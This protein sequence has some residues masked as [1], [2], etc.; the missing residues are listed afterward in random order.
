MPEGSAAR[1]AAGSS[2]SIT[3]VRPASGR[4]LR[5]V[6]QHDGDVVANR[7]PIPARAHA[8]DDLVVLVVLHIASAVRARQDVQEFLVDAHAASPL[9]PPSPSA[10]FSSH[11]SFVLASAFS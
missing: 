1:T 7:V 6:D 4:L 11:S 5:L 10:V 3:E 8:H 9:I 2:R